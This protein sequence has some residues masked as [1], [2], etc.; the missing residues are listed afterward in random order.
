MTVQSRQPGALPRTVWRTP[1]SRDECQFLSFLNNPRA[2]IF[3]IG[4]AG[5]SLE[6]GLPSPLS[7]TSGES[8]VSRLFL[9]DA[10]TGQV[11]EVVLGSG[12]EWSRV[13]ITRVLRFPGGLATLEVTQMDNRRSRRVAFW[14]TILPVV[15]KRTFESSAPTRNLDIAADGR[16]IAGGADAMIHAWSGEN[17][18]WSSGPPQGPFDPAAVGGPQQERLFRSYGLFDFASGDSAD[19]IVQ[20][21]DAQRG[22]TGR[23]RTEIFGAVDG[24]PDLTGYQEQCGILAGGHRRLPVRRRGHRKP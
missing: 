20:R 10:L 21:N 17:P 6:P 2:F 19:L 9:G 8:F 24:H 18:L 4:I 13:A 16:I 5:L 15:P 22:S 23:I 14:D 7:V 1:G 3:V 11:C 12:S